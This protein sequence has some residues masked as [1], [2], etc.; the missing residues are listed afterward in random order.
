MK[1][2][3][4]GCALILLLLSAGCIRSHVPIQYY[5]LNADPT[6]AG[7]I[8][9]A[10]LISPDTVIGIGPVHIPEYLNRPQIVVGV[11]G[12]RY[13]LD[14]DHRWAERLD[15]NI[16][17]TLIESLYAQLG[18]VQIVRHPWAARRKIKYRTRIEILELYPDAQGQSRM[19][20][21]W[22]IGNRDQTFESERFECAIETSAGDFDAFAAAQ[23]ACLGR[24]SVDIAQTLVRLI[25][26]SGTPDRR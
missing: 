8:A 23:S 26:T 25:R 13:R 5:L 6:P 15:E 4:S 2:A 10:A 22:T 11:S 12:N 7:P 16:E 20:A 17:R 14:E 3:I 19:S 9:E 18:E 24:M 1:N 21:Q